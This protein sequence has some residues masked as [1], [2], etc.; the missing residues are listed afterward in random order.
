MRSYRLALVSDPTYATYHG[1][2]N[3]T[4]AK[5]TLINRVNQLYEDDLAIQ[6]DLVANNDLAEPRH[7]RP[8]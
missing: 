6:L 2:A 4:A 5:V 3:V 1:A 7:R 8:R